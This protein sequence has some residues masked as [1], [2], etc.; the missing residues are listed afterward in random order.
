[1]SRINTIWHGQMALSN[2]PQ[3]LA[4]VLDVPVTAI[5]LEL[6]WPNPKTGKLTSFTP[7]GLNKHVLSE[8]RL[9]WK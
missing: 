6:L 3:Y 7:E 2:V 1:M 8:L 5:K 9:L 4:E